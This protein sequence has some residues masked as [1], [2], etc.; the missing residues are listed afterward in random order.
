MSRFSFRFA[1]IAIRALPFALA[2]LR[3]RRRF[4]LFGGARTISTEQHQRRAYRI[5]DAMLELGPTFIKIGQV[6]STRPDVVPKTYAEAF[7][8]LQ[9]TVPAGPYREMIPALAEDIGYHTYDAFDPI[10]FAGGSLA[11]VYEA[12]YESKRVV[13][14]VRRPGIKSLIETDLQV[15]DRLL[16]V[17]VRFAPER[18]RFSLRNIADDFDRIIQE[19]LHFEREARMM[20]EIGENFA[21]EPTVKIPNVYPE[22]SSDRVLTMEYVDGIKITA[23]DELN[24]AGFDPKTIAHETANAY[25]QMGLE[26]GVF[27]GDPHPG[28]LAV[29]EHGRITLYDFGMSGRFAPQ[30]QETVIDLYLAVVTRNVEEIIDLLIDLGALDPAVD[31]AAIARVLELMIA[32]L[33]GE[34]DLNWRVILDEVI[35]AFHDFPFRIPPDLMLVIR[36]GTVSEGVLRQLDPEF[37]FINAA[38]QFLLEHGYM[39]R[40]ARRALE[41]ARD[42]VETALRALARTPPKLERALDRAAQ[43]GIRVESRPSNPQ[44]YLQTIGK[45]IGYALLAGSGAVGASILAS[46][47]A[48]Y[49]AV[50]FLIAGALFVLFIASLRYDP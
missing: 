36:V 20:G 9:D 22:A 11:Q 6:L 49:G 35:D 12:T 50:G 14:K 33:K 29:D 45:P 41:G 39:Q 3:D 15:I 1:R 5:R 43:D 42:D 21:D 37:D 44:L 38:R 26:D 13:V 47:D 8:T 32:D 48:R 27:H 19:E 17:V 4:V 10:P 25:F 23:V 34:D 16:P 28:N 7:A 30:M 40:G 24:D 31:R 46:I 18:H 2:F